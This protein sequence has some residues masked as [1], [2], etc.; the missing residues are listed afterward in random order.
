M[1]TPVLIKGDCANVGQETELPSAPG[2]P[3]AHNSF[4]NR[5]DD[6]GR[7]FGGVKHESAICSLVGVGDR[8]DLDGGG[9]HRVQRGAGEPR[10]RH[11]GRRWP[12]LL[13]RLLRLWL[14]PLL[15]AFL[16]RAD[17]LPAVPPL[18]LAA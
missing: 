4:T 7:L 16:D 13:S 14:L 8:G 18:L 9:F 1:V 3:P 17:R 11:D 2:S 15:R 10:R 12:G 6:E 5:G